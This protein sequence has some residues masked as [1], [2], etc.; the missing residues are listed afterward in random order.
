MPAII[1]LQN[2]EYPNSVFTCVTMM[3]YSKNSVQPSKQE[4]FTIICFFS[5][6]IDE[7]NQKIKKPMEK[8]F[9]KLPN[10]S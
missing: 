1:V 10:K 8:I 6:K 9:V 7:S 4:Y 2:Y 3:L 5:Y